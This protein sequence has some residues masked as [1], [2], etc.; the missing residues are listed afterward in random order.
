MCIPRG[1][2]YIYINREDVAA[3]VLTSREALALAR[4]KDI[5]PKNLGLIY[6]T[7]SDE[8]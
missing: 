5:I 2:L 6:L 1:G 4:F 7:P 8:K 3:F